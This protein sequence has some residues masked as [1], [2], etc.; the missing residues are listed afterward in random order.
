M[1]E[2]TPEDIFEAYKESELKECGKWDYTEDRKKIQKRY[3]EILDG[4]CCKYPKTPKRLRYFDTKNCIHP[5]E[6]GISFL[7]KY[8]FL[9]N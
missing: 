1:I 7:E 8:S 2:N 6:I 4:I 9:L 3:R 5:L